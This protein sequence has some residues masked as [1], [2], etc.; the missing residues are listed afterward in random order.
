MSFF[1]LNI[2]ASSQGYRFYFL[3]LEIFLLLIQ[4]LAMTRSFWPHCDAHLHARIVCCALSAIHHA[5]SF[6]VIMATY[7][8]HVNIPVD[9]ASFTTCVALLQPWSSI[10]HYFIRRN[11]PYKNAFIPSSKNVMSGSLTT[12]VFNAGPFGF[13]LP[14]TRITRKTSWSPTSA[15]THHREKCVKKVKKV[16]KLTSKLSRGIKWRDRKDSKKSVEFAAG[17]LTFPTY[18]LFS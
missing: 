1:L 13:S 12:T 9:V 4:R 11:M 15:Y 6:V 7:R 8:F 17:N 5:Q 2:T 3:R 16:C 10:S 18:I 14:L